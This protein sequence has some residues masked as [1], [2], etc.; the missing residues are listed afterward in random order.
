VVVSVILDNVW[1]G[2]TAAGTKDFTVSPG[3]HSLYFMRGYGYADHV[4]GTVTIVSGQV[5]SVNVNLEVTPT[6]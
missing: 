2:D 1:I 5:T 3:A 6:P 4:Y